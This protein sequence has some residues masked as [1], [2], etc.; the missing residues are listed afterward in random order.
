MDLSRFDAV[1]VQ[2]VPFSPL[3]TTR[4]SKIRYMSF[5]NDRIC[6]AKDDV[7][8]IQGHYNKPQS[9]GGCMGAVTG[10]AKIHTLKV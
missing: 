1:P 10:V 3:E 9:R 5:E 6:V 8:L 2:D 4:R 7:R